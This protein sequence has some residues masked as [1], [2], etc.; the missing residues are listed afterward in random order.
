MRPSV[1]H[2]KKTYEQ[3][4]EDLALGVPQTTI[5]KSLGV[6]ENTVSRWKNRKDFRR[7]LAL[8][9][10]E[11]ARAP[12]EQI[13]LSN[14]ERWLRKKFKEDWGPEEGEGLNLL[15]IMLKGREIDTL[16]AIATRGS[17]SSSDNGE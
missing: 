12:I 9:E 7:D 6:D 15:S 5:A 16:I 11:L 13:K 3:V 4:I 17:N 1:I 2:D 10:I 14:P 8:K